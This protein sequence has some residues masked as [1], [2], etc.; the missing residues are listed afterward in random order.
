VELEG[1][2]LLGH[3]AYRSY[4]RWWS[5]TDNSCDF[6]AQTRFW[7]GSA[8]TYDRYT[9]CLSFNKLPVLTGRHARDARD[10]RDGTA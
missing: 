10:A 7:N 4:F 9:N 5:H 2:R 3:P 6:N 8:L 1:V